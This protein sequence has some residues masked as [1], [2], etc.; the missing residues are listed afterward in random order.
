MSSVQALSTMVSP[1]QTLV[2]PFLKAP[3]K[4]VSLGQ[5]IWNFAVCWSASRQ[6]AISRL[7]CRILIM[8]GMFIY[9]AHYHVTKLR[10]GVQT[11]LHS[12]EF[13]YNSSPRVHFFGKKTNLDSKSNKR[14]I[15]P[16]LVVRLETEVRSRGTGDKSQIWQSLDRIANRDMKKE[17]RKGNRTR[18]FTRGTTSIIHYTRSKVKA[19]RCSTHARP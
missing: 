15:K 18:T 17:K 16:L 1:L 7:F 14:L 6:F 13:S 12:T 5:T 8:F 10:V 19:E 2:P 3:F 4:N 9:F 11:I